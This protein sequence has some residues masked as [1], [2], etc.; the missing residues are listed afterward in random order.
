[1]NSRADAVRY[2]PLEG[3]EAKPSSFQVLLM[4]CVTCF[5]AGAEGIK[6]SQTR[7]VTA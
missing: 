1:M 4:S 2:G 7:L 3:S 6:D 5:L